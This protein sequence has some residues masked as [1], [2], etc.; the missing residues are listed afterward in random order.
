[1]TFQI[2]MVVG[3]LVYKFGAPFA[4]ITSISVAAY[5]AFT[6]TITQVLFISVT[7][8][9]LYVLYAISLKINCV[10]Y[11]LSVSLISYHT[12]FSLHV[13]SKGLMSRC[14]LSHF[15][16]FRSTCF[17]VTCFF[18]AFLFIKF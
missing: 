7:I 4:W 18:S 11:F 2:S 5:I 16:A 9:Y 1:M 17:L 13:S 6:L 3:I 12:N 10:L 15:I 8:V 14:N